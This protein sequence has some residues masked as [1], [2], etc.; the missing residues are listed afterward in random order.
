MKIIGVIGAMDE[1]VAVLKGRMEDVVTS[2]RA[3]MT[4]HE[5]RLFGKDA[6]VVQSGIGKVNAAACSQILVDMYGVDVLINTGIAGALADEVNI[7]DMV[8]ASET[9]H[10]DVDVSVFEY[11]LGQIPRMANLAF[12]SD[13]DLVEMVRDANKCVNPEIGTHVGRIASGD[14]FVASAEQKEMI[15][16]EFQALCTEMEGAAIGQVACLNN[17]PYVI[18]RCISDK[19]DGSASLD[20][21]VFEKRAIDY[22]VNLVGEVFA[23]L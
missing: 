4:F 8:I 17:V 18:I 10:H 14:Q 9:V 11:P 21:K 5:G 16:S 13:K 22:T 7:C 19:A 15:V 12:A 20:Y 2:V 23:R 6:V 3:G 1:E